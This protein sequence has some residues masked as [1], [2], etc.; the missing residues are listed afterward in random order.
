VEPVPARIAE[1]VERLVDEYR[2]RCLWFLRSDYRPEDRDAVLRVLE[3]IERYGDRDGFKRAAEIRQWLS[4]SQRAVCRLL[5][6]TRVASGEYHVAGRVALNEL[7]AAPRRSRDVDLFHDTDAALD[8]TWRADRRLLEES[9]FAVHVVSE[10]AG[11]V[12]AT[13]SPPTST[14]GGF[15]STVARSAVLCPSL[16]DRIA[17]GQIGRREPS[18]ARCRAGGQVG[19]AKVVTLEQ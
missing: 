19:Q 16:L 18:A 6:Q 12:R 9:G 1:A 11:L 15:A 17:I 14:P 7:L 4:R 2:D 3:Y 13:R 10:R 5:A 8:A